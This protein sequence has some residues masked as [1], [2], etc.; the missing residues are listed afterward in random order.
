MFDTNKFKAQ[1]KRWIKDNPDG[2]IDD[3]TNFCEELIPSNLYQT[4]SWLIDQTIYWYKSI[5]NSRQAYLGS[6]KELD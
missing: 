4:H 6:S 5:L 1:V 2:S 3:L